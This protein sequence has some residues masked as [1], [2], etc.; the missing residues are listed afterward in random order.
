VRPALQCALQCAHSLEDTDWIVPMNSL[1]DSGAPK[2][3]TREA[4]PYIVDIQSPGFCDHRGLVLWKS[5]LRNLKK[6][7]KP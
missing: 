5:L 3:A 7:G 2:K 1:F 4:Y 6:Y